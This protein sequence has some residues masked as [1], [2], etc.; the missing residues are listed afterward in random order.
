[1]AGTILVAD[2]GL[3]EAGRLELANILELA[4]SNA[5]GALQ[6]IANLA[7]RYPTSPQVFLSATGLDIDRLLRKSHGRVDAL[8]SVLR[9][10]VDLDVS[11]VPSHHAL[12]TARLASACRW[13]VLS[14]PERREFVAGPLQPMM[15]AMATRDYDALA[16]LALDREHELLSDD[17]RLRCREAIQEFAAALRQIDPVRYESGLV[18]PYFRSADRLETGTDLVRAQ[19]VVLRWLEL[20]L[21]LVRRGIAPEKWPERYV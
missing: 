18:E 15:A 13:E 2:R 14:L 4:E 12:C 7:R 11:Y 1:V 10:V 21:P 9:A 3:D 6:Q 17:W 8:V 16:R 20:W 5:L 19:A